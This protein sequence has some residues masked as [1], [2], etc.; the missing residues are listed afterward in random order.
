M[1]YTKTPLFITLIYEYPWPCTNA[2]IMATF[3]QTLTELYFP[4]S[5]WAIINPF[6]WTP[7]S[8]TKLRSGLGLAKVSPRASWVG[9]CVSSIRPLP[10]TWICFISTK[11]KA[12]GDNN[13][14]S[15]H[16]IVISH[17]S[18]IWCMFYLWQL[19]L[20]T[21]LL[22]PTCLYDLLI[23]CG[24]MQQFWCRSA[25][26]RTHRPNRQ[27]QL[28]IGLVLQQTSRWVGKLTRWYTK[29]SGPVF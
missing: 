21:F 9:N 6:Y 25:P 11:V 13:K 19:Y 17:L 22:F 15:N 4:S 28:V 23:R 2:L 20:W 7:E 29:Y 26:E 24:K 16:A 1:Q 14:V 12:D 10:C 27:N 3:W 8:Q 5:D 18:C